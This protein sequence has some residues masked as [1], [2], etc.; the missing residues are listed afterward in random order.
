MFLYGL[1]Q[2]TRVDLPNTP[3]TI[4]L[5]RSTTISINW[6]KPWLLVAETEGCC[7]TSGCGWGGV[8]GGGDDT[9]VEPTDPGSLK[10]WALSSGWSKKLRLNSDPAS[11]DT[12]ALSLSGG[13]ALPRFALRDWSILKTSMSSPSSRRDTCW[14]TRAAVRPGTGGGRS[15]NPRSGGPSGLP[16]Y[17]CI[18]TADFCIISRC[19]P[20]PAPSRRA[21]ELLSLQGQHSPLQ[22]ALTTTRFP[23]RNELQ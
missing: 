16:F 17:L 13:G 2:P 21:L 7:S 5:D 8:G 23:L 14:C 4:L 10:P 3:S 19:S 18:L 1:L 6:I 20:V 12:S 9:E 22:S 15:T 11:K